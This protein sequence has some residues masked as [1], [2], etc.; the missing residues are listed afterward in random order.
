MTGLC[1]KD[2]YKKKLNLELT[3]GDELES[4]STVS[5]IGAKGMLLI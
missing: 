5:S 2:M 1:E 3:D 4:T